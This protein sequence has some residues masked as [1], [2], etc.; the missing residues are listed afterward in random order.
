MHLDP[1]DRS[2][3]PHAAGSL[4]SG[5]TGRDVAVIACAAA[6][7]AVCV[8]IILGAIIYARRN[9]QLKPMPD[10]SAKKIPVPRIWRDPRPSAAG[11]LLKSGKLHAAV[12]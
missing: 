12:Y 8:G 9:A 11:E 5:I 2:L 3:C 1:P 7:G 6:G 4:L 10:D